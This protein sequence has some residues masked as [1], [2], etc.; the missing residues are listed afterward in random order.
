MMGKPYYASLVENDLNFD[1]TFF[2]HSASRTDGR[3][4]IK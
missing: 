1:F 4:Y 2:F 3:A